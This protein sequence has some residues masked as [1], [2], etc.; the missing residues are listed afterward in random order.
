MIVVLSAYRP[1]LE[2]FLTARGEKIVA[3]IP[4]SMREPREST[5][6]R[7]P[8]R[9]IDHF[10]DYTEL[11]RIAVELEAL[12]VTAVATIDEPC[13]RAAAF[14]NELLGLPGLDHRSAVACTDKSVMKRRLAAAG[15]PVA[16]HRV[17]HDVRQIRKFLDDAGGEIV[18]KPRYGF[19]TINTHRVNRDNFDQLASAGAFGPPANLPEW[20]RST[21][22]AS[23]VGQVGC[24][25]E[26]F[27]DVVEEFHCE[28]MLHR[29]SEVHCLAGRY[30]TPVLANN[31]YGSVLLDPDSA[32]AIEVRSLTRA[33]ASALGVTDGFGH[34][35]IFRDRCGRWLVGEFAARP[36]GLLIPRMLRL[37]YGI[38][39]L[40]LLVE[41]LGGRRPRTHAVSRGSFSWAV[42]PVTGSGVIAGMPD[43]ADLLKVPGVI[44]AQIV[45]RNGDSTGDLQGA[46]L[47]A[48]YIICQGD[49]PERA[50]V[51]ARHAQ[52]SCRITAV[53]APEDSSED[54]SSSASVPLVE[55]PL[56]HRLG[57]RRRAIADTE[58]LV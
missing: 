29:G 38:D 54:R 36:G 31:A 41:Q 56:P 10:D 21:S 44:E 49:T 19:G 28:L 5:N 32:D 53:P 23:D 22:L 27:V 50:E 48:A 43:E 51:F 37:S 52:R 25:V 46:M 13:V 15:V 16:E 35:E 55:Q 7:Y 6:P 20:I 57:D 34:C 18:V 24:L 1:R 45:L 30:F 17:V 3:V 4:E 26:R 11:A 40:E 39:N 58:L 2:D 12:G 47:H 14:V 42:I 8:I 33:A 9:T